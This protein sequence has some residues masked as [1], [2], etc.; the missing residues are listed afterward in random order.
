[1][2]IKLLY[3]I[4]SFSLVFSAS[5][6]IYRIVDE[7]GK[8]TFTDN[9]P[10]DVPTKEK[11]HLPTANIQ[12]ALKPAPAVKAVEEETGRYQEIVILAPTQDTT[13]P[14]GQ[15]TMTV[16]VGLKPLLKAGHLIQLLLSG[17]PYGLPTATMS[18]RID[19]LIRGENTVQV[20]VIDTEGRVIGLSNT[21]TIHVKR[22]SALHPNN[23]QSPPPTPTPH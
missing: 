3:T 4:L 11:V 9:P 22:G 23:I 6:E 21:T 15:E 8:V 7:D 10:H 5:A 1:M 12:P 2:R 13:I 16:Q 17:Q 18:F 14:P 19:A 20:Q